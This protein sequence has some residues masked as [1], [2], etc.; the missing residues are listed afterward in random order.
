MLS[1]YYEGASVTQSPAVFDQFV[2]QTKVSLSVG[3]LQPDRKMN[4]FSVLWRAPFG[5]RQIRVRELS[6]G[7][8]RQKHLRTR[9]RIYA[10][11]RSIT[12]SLSFETLH[13]VVQRRARRRDG[14][15]A[16]R[17][18]GRNPRYCS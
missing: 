3:L 17:L 18:L 15:C 16:A 7:A 1:N 5:F 14:I 6:P 8:L 10:S 11:A 9:E 4:A 12:R 13:P 2:N